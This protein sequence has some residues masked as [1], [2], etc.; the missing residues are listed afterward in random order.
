M[1]A[2]SGNQRG[3]MGHLF[4]RT[5][6]VILWRQYIPR[7]SGKPAREIASRSEPSF[8]AR[9]GWF[10]VLIVQNARAR[11]AAPPPPP[12][13]LRSSSSAAPPPPPRRGPARLP[14]VSMDKQTSGEDEQDAR[15]GLSGA[16]G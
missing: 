15:P 13:R 6:R 2:V 1:G 14:G 9:L 3:K 12:P 5:S 7:L 10:A 16:I 11:A 8:S 4:G